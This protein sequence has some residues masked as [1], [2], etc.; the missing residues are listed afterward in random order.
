MDATEVSWDSYLM[1]S[2]DLLSGTDV[3]ELP[4]TEPGDLFDELFPPIDSVRKKP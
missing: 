3:S 4:D 2:F 1:S